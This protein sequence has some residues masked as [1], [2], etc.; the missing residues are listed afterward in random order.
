[1]PNQNGSSRP[2]N[3]R[4]TDLTV[5]GAWISPVE[6]QDQA[7]LYNS[8]FCLNKQYPSVFLNHHY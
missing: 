7:E 2:T 1:M 3:R 6:A 5:E 8:T 4:D